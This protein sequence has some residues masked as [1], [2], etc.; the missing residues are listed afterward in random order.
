MIT[1]RSSRS[2]SL[3]AAYLGEVRVGYVEQT[4]TRRFRMQLIFLQPGGN[5]YF[6]VFDTE[7]D[8]RAALLVSVEHWLDAAGLQQRKTNP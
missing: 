7:E 4:L 8:A 1:W 2:N 6:G 5:S 3:H